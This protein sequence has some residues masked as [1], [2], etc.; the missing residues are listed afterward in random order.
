M[1]QACL[2]DAGELSGQSGHAVK[3]SWPGLTSPLVRKRSFGLGAPERIRTSA[4]LQ[5]SDSAALPTLA[6]PDTADATHRSNRVC[7]ISTANNGDAAAQDG[8]PAPATHQH[9]AEAD[10]DRRAFQSLMHSPSAAVFPQAAAVMPIRAV[11]PHSTAR[12]SLDASLRLAA[13][14]PLVDGQDGVKPEDE[15]PMKRHSIAHAF[16]SEDQPLQSRRTGT[17]AKAGRPKLTID[18]AASMVMREDS[19]GLDSGGHGP[20]VRSPVVLDTSSQ[21]SDSGRVASVLAGSSRGSES[22]SLGGFSSTVESREDDSPTKSSPAKAEGLWLFESDH[23]LSDIPFQGTAAQHKV[24]GTLTTSCS[25]SLTQ[26]D[27]FAPVSNEAAAK[28]GERKRSTSATLDTRR[29]SHPAINMSTAAAQVGV[30]TSAD[31]FN[32]GRPAVTGVHVPTSTSAFSEGAHQASGTSAASSPFAGERHAEVAAGSSDVQSLIS[33]HQSVGFGSVLSGHP[34]VSSDA[35]D[36]RSSLSFGQASL[37]AERCFQYAGGCGISNSPIMTAPKTAVNMEGRSNS[38]MS[39]SPVRPQPAASS[40]TSLCTPGEVTPLGAIPVTMDSWDCRARELQAVLAAAARIQQRL[41]LHATNKGSGPGGCTAQPS[42]AKTSTA[43][44]PSASQEQQNSASSIFC[45]PKQAIGDQHEL[46]AHSTNAA[47]P[48]AVA[49]LPSS[50]AP[51]ATAPQNARPKSILKALPS[52]LPV[53]IALDTVARQKATDA[54]AGGAAMNSLPAQSSSNAACSATPS[55]ETVDVSQTESFATYQPVL[56][57]GPLWTV[58]DEALGHPPSPGIPH[59]AAVDS[60]H[61]LNS[62]APL[63]PH[64]FP[65][66]DEHNNSQ[67]C[68]GFVMQGGPP[69]SPICTALTASTPMQSNYQACKTPGSP[70][71]TCLATPQ[72]ACNAHIPATHEFASAHSHLRGQSVVGSNGRPHVRSAAA[73]SPSSHSGSDSE[74]HSPTVRSAP[75]LGGSNER[76]ES[77][78]VIN[79]SIPDEDHA[80][81]ASDPINIVHTPLSVQDLPSQSA[82]DLH[83]AEHRRMPRKHQLAGR[84]VDNH[85]GAAHISTGCLASLG[86]AP[87]ASV[88]PASAAAGPTGNSPLAA[89]AAEPSLSAADPLAAA[90]AAVISMMAGSALFVSGARQLVSALGAIEPAGKKAAATRHVEGFGSPSLTNLRRWTDDASPSGIYGSRDNSATK[91]WQG[92]SPTSGDFTTPSLKLQQQQQQ[93]EAQLLCLPVVALKAISS[94]FPNIPTAYKSP[95]AHRITVPR[96]LLPE[97]T[98][99]NGSMAASNSPESACI[100]HEISFSAPGLTNSPERLRGGPLAVYSGT[101][102]SAG[103][104][105]SETHSPALKDGRAVPLAELMQLTQR[106][107]DDIAMRAE[108]S[109]KAD[110]LMTIERALQSPYAPSE[111]PDTTGYSYSEGS[112]I[113]ALQQTGTPI[114]PACSTAQ[115][116][117]LQPTDAPPCSGFPPPSEGPDTA[118]CSYMHDSCLSEELQQ[119]DSPKLPGHSTQTVTRPP[120]HPLARSFPPPTVDL[121]QINAEGEYVMKRAYSALF[122]VQN[123]AH[124]VESEAK[125]AV[126]AADTS[127]AQL[128]SVMHDTLRRLSSEAMDGASRSSEDRKPLH[129]FNDWLHTI[130]QDQIPE[131][132]GQL[133][134]HASYHCADSGPASRESDAATC[135]TE[136][137]DSPQST[138]FARG[139]LMPRPLVQGSGLEQ[140]A[141][142]QS[143]PPN[144]ASVHNSGCGLQSQGS[145]PHSCKVRSSKPVLAVEIPRWE[146]VFLSPPASRE[147]ADTASPQPVSLEEVSAALPHADARESLSALEQGASCQE[148]LPSPAAASNESDRCPQRSAWHEALFSPVDRCSDDYD[149]S[150]HLPEDSAVSDDFVDEL[151]IQSFGGQGPSDLQVGT[152]Y[153]C[154]SA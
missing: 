65:N 54:A 152:T 6:V 92:A 109:D 135:Y 138:P 142:S 149:D 139:N 100:G 83:M 121:E 45:G 91:Q 9:S 115:V 34:S 49:A 17:C 35:T 76:S 46:E 108:H 102:Y 80:E 68:D 122:S 116:L 74:N 69:E 97:A 111:G 137:H 11:T 82:Q 18:V 47:R 14:E 44:A 16:Q 150:L 114:V 128:D 31:P 63:M 134:S 73:L 140:G 56:A 120:V 43:E 41:T 86:L 148:A 106:L 84:F 19:Q 87:A 153:E 39:I 30:L 93:P 112:G 72:T 96:A 110:S 10:G 78:C 146:D 12:S 90:T 67:T 85:D 59:A 29:A 77:A 123:T 143:G 33:K 105:A 132:L 151:C 23:Q 50:S 24:T 40:A 52:S 2:G 61:P 89:A 22:A 129:D 60:Y 66:F 48:V 51:S 88:P 113:P 38:D 37:H 136:P 99:P 8:T 58:S 42:T 101:A 75:M 118:D 131:A 98:S 32:D 94:E 27:F 3:S 64:E 103:D 7:Q 36:V 107:G 145:T 21:G 5:A 119:T 133:E 144:P 127:L 79:F 15:S 13:P 53:A 130:S 141:F 20:T 124:L 1:I 125:A 117:D 104:A 70:I 25:H 71:L 81:W 62:H 55:T 147:G 57:N 126:A 28:P 26:S 4:A 95:K 154:V